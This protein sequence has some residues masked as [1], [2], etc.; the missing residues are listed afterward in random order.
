MACHPPGEVGRRAATFSFSSAARDRQALLWLVKQ[1]YGSRL[2]ALRKEE[3]GGMAALQLAI[4]INHKPR[5][6]ATCSISENQLR[7]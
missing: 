2:S 6:K 5:R 3:G 1:P 7:A 4:C